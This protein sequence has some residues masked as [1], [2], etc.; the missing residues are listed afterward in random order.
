MRFLLPLLG[1]LM[2]GL[3]VSPVVANGP[4]V[5]VTTPQETSDAKAAPPTEPQAAEPKT[6]EEAIQKANDLAREK[7]PEGLS[8]EEKQQYYRDK[9]VKVLAL[10][11]L[12]LT[13]NPEPELRRKA[14]VQQFS[15]LAMLA[16]LEVEG[17]AERRDQFMETA[18]EDQDEQ[19]AVFAKSMRFSGRLQGLRELSPEERTEQLTAMKSELLAAKPSAAT[20][21]QV[22]QYLMVGTRGME[23]AQAVNEYKEFSAHFATSEDESLRKDAEALEATVR[24]LTLPGN[25]IEVTGKTL[26]GEDFSMGSLQGKVVLVD[27]WA[28]WCGPCIAEFPEMRKLYQTYKPHGFEVVG[29]SLDDDKEKLTTFMAK[30]DVPWIVLWDPNS[31]RGWDNPVAVNYGIDAIPCMILVNKEGKVVSTDA[32]GKKLK[33]LLAEMYPDVK[34]IE[35]APTEDKAEATA[36]VTP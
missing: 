8:D 31:K 22:K 30:Q 28:T 35:E 34:M 27:F 10:N 9:F 20:L 24:R 7:M 21:N 11:E 5:S 19:I 36:P 26:A 33:E 12:A 32:R 6:A 23:T 2:S 4:F 29:I 17:M 25:A 16:N 15:I 14:M 18:A 1:I 13:L 3:L